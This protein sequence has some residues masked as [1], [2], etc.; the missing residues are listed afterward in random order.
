MLYPFIYDTK[1][2]LD[3]VKKHCT[4]E[5]KVFIETDNPEDMPEHMYDIAIEMTAY[6]SKYHKFLKAA[7]D[8]PKKYQKLLEAACDNSFEFL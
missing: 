5:T 3:A 7:C 2:F 6:F 8:D 4:N 1:E